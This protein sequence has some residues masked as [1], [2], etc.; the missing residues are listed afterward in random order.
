MTPIFELLSKHFPSSDIT[1][2]ENLRN[3]VL[4]SGPILPFATDVWP[5]SRPGGHVL[6]KQSGNHAAVHRA[7]DRIDMRNGTAHIGERESD[8][9]CPFQVRSLES[10]PTWSVDL[11]HNIRSSYKT[12]VW[13]RQM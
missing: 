12:L 11:S 2:C 9:S 4:R 6:A 3:H 8:H 5:P 13:V 10:R 1:G 7:R